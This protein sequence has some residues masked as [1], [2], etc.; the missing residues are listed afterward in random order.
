M[1]HFSYSLFIVSIFGAA[2]ACGL[3]TVNLVGVRLAVRQAATGAGNIS[4]LTAEPASGAAG[5][6]GTVALIGTVMTLAATIATRAVAAGRPPLGNMYEYNIA[7]AWGVLVF[8]ALF[9]IKYRQRASGMIAAALA[10]A[11]LVINLKFFPSTLVTLVPALQANRI[12]G[13]HVATMVVSYAAL[14]VSFAAAVLYLAQGNARRFSGVPSRRALD[15]IA[16]AS[17]MIGFPL[18]ALGIALGAWWAN[19]AWGRYWGWDP[20]ETSALV[21]WL[22]YAVYLH[23]HHLK[24]WRNERSA[25]I[26]VLGY[27]GVLYTYF[28]VNIW[29]AGLHSY[30]GV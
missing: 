25:W 27:V 9:E 14:S 24:S 30:A 22:I 18:L 21:T 15:Q 11:I 28:V 7:L 20:K 23:A 12:L 8:S 4:M 1:E 2:L 16:E 26:L 13:I 19:S 10:L 17:V 6:A 29:V 5:R 3:Y